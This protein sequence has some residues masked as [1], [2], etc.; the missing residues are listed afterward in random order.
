[1]LKFYLN[2]NT[3]EDSECE[4]DVYLNINRNIKWD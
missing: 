1:M 3:N 2:G 4:E